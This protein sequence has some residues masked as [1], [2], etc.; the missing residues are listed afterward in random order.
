MN[1]R[2]ISVSTEKKFQLVYNWIFIPVWNECRN[3]Y[4]KKSVEINRGL[5]PLYFANKILTK[6][7]PSIWLLLHNVKSTVKIFSNFVAF[8]E[9][10]KLLYILI[11][12]LQAFPATIARVCSR[13]KCYNCAN[14]RMDLPDTFFSKASTQL[15]FWPRVWI[16]RHSSEHFL[17]SSQKMPA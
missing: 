5:G 16:K 2:K 10:I 15:L 9:N 1:W 6:S 7:S 4:F 8:L 3:G 11:L 17:L 12:E 14:C 13:Q